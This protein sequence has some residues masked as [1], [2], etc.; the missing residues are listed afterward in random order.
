MNKLLIVFCVIAFYVPSAFGKACNEDP[1]AAFGLGGFGNADVT[2][3]K[4]DLS[5]QLIQCGIDNACKAAGLGVL[6][7]S[8]CSGL[9]TAIVDAIFDESAAQCAANGAGAGVRK[10]I[11]KT[12]KDAAINYL[13]KEL[14]LGALGQA[15]VKDF[16]KSLDQ[17]LTAGKCAVKIGEGALAL[18]ANIIRCVNELPGPV[19]VPTAPKGETIATFSGESCA[20]SI[21]R[22]GYRGFQTPCAQCCTE[23]IVKGR[24]EGNTLSPSDPQQ[25]MLSCLDHCKN[26]RS[27]V[28][29]PST[30]YQK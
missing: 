19:T 5:K 8:L 6:G 30:R 22:G 1:A 9:S 20:Q 4:D 3:Y 21:A 26:P 14:G 17:L 7:A 27:T 18:C 25:F 10:G 28:P 29:E 15:S 12:I 24:D 13:S 23:S 11:E 16:L 2:S